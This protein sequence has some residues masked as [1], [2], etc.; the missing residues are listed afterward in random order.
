VA[1]A[2][3][4]GYIKAVVVL[5]GF[6]LGANNLQ[7]LH[8]TK[9]GPRTVEGRQRIA[10]AARESARLR[11]AD[12]RRSGERRRL[13]E[14]SDEGL[15]AL[16]SARTGKKASPETREKISKASKK[17]ELDKLFQRVLDPYRHHRARNPRWN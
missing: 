11:W 14:L 5:R 1:A 15:E 10:A 8:E 7:P 3:L 16:R 12:L 13:G 17:R 6:R 2:G 4:D 9:P